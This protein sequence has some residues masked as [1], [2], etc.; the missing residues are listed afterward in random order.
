MT[1]D[2]DIGYGKPP[3]HS[4]FKP[5]RSGNSSGR[6]KGRT[7]LKTDLEDE[8]SEKIRIVTDGKFKNI[9][10]QRA[11]IKRLVG[12]AANGDPRAINILITLMTKLFGDTDTVEVESDFTETDRAIL[13]DFAAR[14]IDASGEEGDKK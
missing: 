11:T 3:K 13:D 1:R 6:P 2:Y 10:K 14:I 9:S 12:N 7:N 5:G 8:L 4:Q